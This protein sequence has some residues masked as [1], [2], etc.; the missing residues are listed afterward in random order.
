M[1]IFN[2]QDDQ[3]LG[4][5]I[6]IDSSTVIVRVDDLD[7]LK[8]IHVNRL[9][10]TQSCSSGQYLIGIVSRVVR[11]PLDKDISQFNEDDLDLVDLPENNLV[12]LNLIGT[13]LDRDKK[14][15]ITFKRTLESL[16]EIDANCFA[17]EGKNL[18]EF[19]RIISN[20]DQNKQQLHLGNYTLDTDAAAYLNGN[21]L[22]QRHAIVV[23]S[24]GSGKSWTTARLLEQVATLK[25]ANGILFDLHGEYS[26]LKGDE[27]R[28]FKVAGSNDLGTNLGISD[29]ILYLPYWL[30]GYE[31][32]TSLFVER[33]DQNAPNQ[34]MLMREC[35]TQAKRDYLTTNKCDDLLDRFTVDSPIPFDLDQV[36]KALKLKN[37]EQVPSKVS[38]KQIKG[39]FNDKLGRMIARFESKC[40]DRR[41]GFMFE[42]NDECKKMDW[43]GRMVR[44]LIC[45]RDSQDDSKGGI[46]IIDFSE[47][48]SDILPLV[49]SL[50]ARLIFTVMQ[51]AKNESFT[52]VALFCDE[53][54]LYI[55]KSTNESIAN[56]ISVGIFERIA[57]EGRKYGVG[58]VVI[59]QRPSEV[60]L[61][62]LSQCSNVIAMRLT[63]QD[64]Q[65]VI[66]HLLPD[67]LGGFADLLPILDIGEALVVGDASMLPIRVQVAKP[68]HEP[69][70]ATIDFWDTWS[71]GKSEHDIDKAILAWRMQSVK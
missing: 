65:S 57:K 62:V 50:L 25:Q 63:N 55:P 59:S 18:T 33:S 11:K 67:K 47:V 60:N 23:G 15:K 39:D 31:A 2:F 48:P 52:P 40:E 58:L 61:T 51:W 27:Y 37:E 12:Y 8:R 4:R 20:A 26:T 43:L 41:L 30:L 7:R 24:T 68:N 44:S 56:A 1:S 28:H 14:E 5:T 13:L 70:S 46:K 69:K 54:H 66:R 35:I 36:G 21:K 19:M 38:N 16:P 42:P 34:T 64:D 9:M 29:G 32:M 3:S 71:D 49:V 53:A 6:S 22:F 45:G 10:A 17:I